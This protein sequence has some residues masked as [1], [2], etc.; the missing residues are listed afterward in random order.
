MATTSASSQ[1]AQVRGRGN[2]CRIISGRLSPEA[3]PSFAE[4]DL[5]QHRHQVGGDDDPEQQIAELGAALDIG[6]E[7]AGIH[8]GDGGDER[9]SQKREETPHEPTPRGA[10]EDRRGVP[11]GRFDSLPRGHGAGKIDVGVFASGHKRGESPLGG[12]LDCRRQRPANHLL[13]A[14]DLEPEWSVKGQ[15]LQQRYPRPGRNAELLQI[16]QSLRILIGDAT[17]RPP[18]ARG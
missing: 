12:D 3:M 1:S 14:G 7:V 11:L 4:S 2:S 15:R 10:F 16:A 9:R 17:A 8:V 18:S 6:G 5:H 13:D